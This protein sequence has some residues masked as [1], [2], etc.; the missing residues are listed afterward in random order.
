MYYQ[1]NYTYSLPT[2]EP[3][4]QKQESESTRQCRCHKPHSLRTSLWPTRTALP[5]CPASGA[6]SPRQRQLF[7]VHSL[8]VQG[9]S[10]SPVFPRAQRAACTD[11]S[12]CLCTEAAHKHTD[13]QASSTSNEAVLGLQHSALSHTPD[14]YCSQKN[15]GPSQQPCSHRSTEMETCFP[16]SSPNSKHV[17]SHKPGYEQGHSFKPLK[18][19]L[20][21]NKSYTCAVSPLQPNL[22]L[23]L[24][25]PLVP[26]CSTSTRSADA[27]HLQPVHCQ[28]NAK[29]LAMMEEQRFILPPQFKNDVADSMYLSCKLLGH[30]L[31]LDKKE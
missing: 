13:M 26:G 10:S 7:P 29:L 1:T 2:R 17:S 4:N 9:V 21:P 20:L 25:A 31:F 24:P 11:A 15:T 8:S 18:F 16:N 3:S 14:R 19:P 30:H 6:A 5:S 22:H 23:C 28:T 12:A 27:Q